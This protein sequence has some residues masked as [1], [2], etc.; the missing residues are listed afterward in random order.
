MMVEMMAILVPFLSF[1]TTFTP[2]KA[3]IMLALMLD[4]H[5]KCLDVVKTFAGWE[6]IMD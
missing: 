3:H 1:A 6:K 2:N 5:F 4:L